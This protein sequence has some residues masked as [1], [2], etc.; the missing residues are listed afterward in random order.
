MASIS[1]A[2]VEVLIPPPVDAGEAP[3]NIKSINK[4]SVPSYTLDMSIVLNPA[5]REV[6]D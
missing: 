2:A 5:V 4:N 1:T 6:T 3:I